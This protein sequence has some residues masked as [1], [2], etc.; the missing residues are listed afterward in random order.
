MQGKHYAI[1]YKKVIAEGTPRNYAH[2]SRYGDQYERGF[3]INS[4]KYALGN[5]PN[6]ISDLTQ[7]NKVLKLESS[8]NFIILIKWNR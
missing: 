6:K 5:D 1:G 7:I 2:L 4:G 3:H 8:R